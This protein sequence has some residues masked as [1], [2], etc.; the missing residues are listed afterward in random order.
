MKFF[1]S[2]VFEWVT[3]TIQ[4]ISEV[5]IGMLNFGILVGEDP[6]PEEFF[7]L[8]EEL[9][10]EYNRTHKEPRGRNMNDTVEENGTKE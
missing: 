1:V 6:T 4:S 3:I 10:E 8:F 7:G 2:M 5:D 9:L